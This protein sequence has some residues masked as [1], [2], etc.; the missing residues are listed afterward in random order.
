MSDQD[1]SGQTHH[2]IDDDLDGYGRKLL[3]EAQIAKHVALL[4]PEAPKPGP[5]VVNAL[6]EIKD[7]LHDVLMELQQLR[8]VIDQTKN[9][10]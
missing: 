7:V 4:T 10:S 1:T 8:N 3:V 9:K 6:I 2:V 5:H